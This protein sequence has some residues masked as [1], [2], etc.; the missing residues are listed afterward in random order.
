MDSST[1]KRVWKEIKDVNADFFNLRT[2][3]APA[4]DDEFSQFY[5]VMSPN[6]GAMAHMTV[7]G[8]F[9]IP[10]TYP[11]SPP[12]VHLF[13]KTG[14]CNADVY[15]QDLGDRR[16]STLCFD[17][18]RSQAAGGAW[19][20]EYTIS[21]LFASLMSAIVSFYVPQQYGPDVAEYVSMK[22]LDSIKKAAKEQ[23]LF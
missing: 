15:S 20:S 13:T 17:I 3:I 11:Q 12:V 5:F 22:K 16:H 7:A 2:V 4:P 21:L 14:R 19:N 18:L 1:R 6:D 8:C 10:D 23:V 9:Y